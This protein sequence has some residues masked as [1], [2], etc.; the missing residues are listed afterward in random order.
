[1]FAEMPARV[2]V[3]LRLDDDQRPIAMTQPATIGGA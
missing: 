3:H 2:D 1:M